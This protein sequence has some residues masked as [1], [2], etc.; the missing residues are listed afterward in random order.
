V[1]RVADALRGIDPKHKVQ[2]ALELRDSIEVFQATD[3]VRFLHKMMP[4]FLKV[5]GEGQPI[6][7]STIPEQVELRF[8]YSRM[9][10][11]QKVRVCLLEI[12]HRLP[13]NDHLKDYA[14]D[15]MGLLMHILKTDNEEN[16]VI[17]LKIMIDLHRNYKTLVADQVQPFLDF[18]FEMYSNMP[19]IVKDAFDTNSTIPGSTPA[20]TVLPSTVH[21]NW[22]PAFSPKPGSVTDELEGGDSAPKTLAK[23][24]M[25]F[26]TLTEC[27]IIVVLLL[28][29]H[30]N[31]I[32]TNMPRLVPLI[33]DV[34]SSDSVSDGRCWH[35]RL[36]LKQKDTL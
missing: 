15:I 26:K 21:T 33:M 20:A 22:Q 31:V 8:S 6:F 24:T 19:A 17:S 2:H 1:K 35:F 28:Q 30:R 32:A 4:V 3:Y 16:A 23:S 11:Y 9:L 7:V 13:I 25:S 5:L 18:V 10:M 12:L 36:V 27:P 34:K 14:K 29:I